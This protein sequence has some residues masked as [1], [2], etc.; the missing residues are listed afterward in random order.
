MML[1]TVDPI[2]SVPPTICAVKVP[3]V[4]VTTHG[5]GTPYALITAMAMLAVPVAV[6]VAVDG[7]VNCNR[8]GLETAPSALALLPSK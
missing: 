4:E 7:R 6:P 5:A 1:V 2:V 8:T 3:T